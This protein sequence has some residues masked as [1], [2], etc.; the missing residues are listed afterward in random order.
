[1]AYVLGGKPYIPRN[2]SLKRPEEVLLV[3]GWEDIAPDW[4]RSVFTA[5]GDSDPVLNI[6]FAPIAVLEA[7]VPELASYRPQIVAFRNTQGFRDTSQLMTV[8]GMEQEA[9]AKIAQFL[10]V[11]SDVFQVT[12]RAEVG[13][14]VEIRR[15]VL[16]RGIT[17]AKLTPLCEDIVFTGAKS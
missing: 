1:M 5:W 15:F 10:T 17:S 13:T 4:I 11:R 3:A 8:T 9:Y 6:N 16:K 14:W 7:L 2:G 12:V